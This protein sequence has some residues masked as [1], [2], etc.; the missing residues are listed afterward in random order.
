MGDFKKNNVF[1]QLPGLILWIII[2]IFFNDTATTE[3]YTLNTTMRIVG[4]I[5]LLSATIFRVYMAI[6]LNKS[7]SYSLEI[8][9]G[10]QL[11]TSGLYKY[12]R[13]PIYTGV[14]LGASSIPIY[15]SSLRGFLIT[16]LVIPLFMYRIGNEERM[17]IEEYGE[18]YQK[19]TWKLFP[20]IY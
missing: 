10:H 1:F 9:E 8:R 15:S 18:E 14:I 3:I 6:T 19:Q 4:V 5:I 11:V 2:L 17:L 20:Y 16:I 13:H 12:I 7:Y